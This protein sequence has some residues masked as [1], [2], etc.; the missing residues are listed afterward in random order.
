MIRY[1]GPSDDDLT[2]YTLAES[3]SSPPLFGVPVA[4]E[5]Y[6]FECGKLFGVSAFLDGSDAFDKVR[7]ELQRLCGPATFANIPANL[8]KWNWEDRGIQIQLYFDA[9]HQRATV[10]ATCS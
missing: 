6:Q 1:T 5:C 3:C 8:Y 10:N 9:S 2:T 4:S 7:Y